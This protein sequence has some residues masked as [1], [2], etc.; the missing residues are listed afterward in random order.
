MIIDQLVGF[1]VVELTHWVQILNLT[2]S[3]FSEFIPRFNGTIILVVGDV[4]VNSEMSVV[5]S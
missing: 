4:P 1:L 5:T 2:R 3:Y